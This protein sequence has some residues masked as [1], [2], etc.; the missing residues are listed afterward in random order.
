ML[1]FSIGHFYF[2]PSVYDFAESATYLILV[3]V[4]LYFK[5]AFHSYAA[6]GFQSIAV[7]PTKFTSCHMAASNQNG[8]GGTC[9][10]MGNGA[11]PEIDVEGSGIM[12]DPPSTGADT[13]VVGVAAPCGGKCLPPPWPHLQ[14][15]KG[16]YEP[17]SLGSKCPLPP[18]PKGIPRLLPP[19]L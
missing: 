4:I 16:G 19:A 15:Q 13:V 12:V 3:I 18:P 6:L 1:Q 9:A 11:W 5:I 2:L 14:P 10:G 7:K 17:S 8:A